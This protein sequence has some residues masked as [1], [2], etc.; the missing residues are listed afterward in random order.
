[1]SA[2]SRTWLVPSRLVATHLVLYC[3]YGVE[4]PL[5]I[6]RR[7]PVDAHH[8]RLS[9]STM[10]RMRA[11]F[12]AYDRP[13]LDWPLWTAPECATVDEV[14]EAWVAEGAAIRDLIQMEL[15]PAY[16]VEYRT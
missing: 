13:R 8:L 12:N 1:M 9:E 2:G 3:D 10:A 15:G 6:D 16:E 5:W 14:E 4:W 11:W 7:G